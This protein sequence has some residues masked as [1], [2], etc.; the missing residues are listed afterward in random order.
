MV[1]A[2]STSSNFR[3]ATKYL[4]NGSVTYKEEIL[5]VLIEEK[6]DLL[7]LPDPISV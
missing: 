4:R 5:L 7:G 2:I 1:I 3:G 6:Q